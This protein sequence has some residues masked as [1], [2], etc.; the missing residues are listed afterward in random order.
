MKIVR[1]QY[2][3]TMKKKKRD[4]EEKDKRG[5]RWVR[6]SNVTRMKDLL[7]DCP[8]LGPSPFYSG[9]NGH[10]LLYLPIRED[11]VEC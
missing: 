9:G 11:N 1:K 3:F 5:R 4:H 8:S 2:A 7:F 10:V 6:A